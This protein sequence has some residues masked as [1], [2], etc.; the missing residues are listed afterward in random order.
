MTDTAREIQPDRSKKKDRIVAIV[1]ALSF[2]YLIN[3]TFG[4]FELL[5]DQLPGIGNIDEAFATY[6]CINSLLYFGVDIRWIF[7]RWWWK[8]HE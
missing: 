7:Q 1:G 4:L 5:P 8:K 6:V 2:L 3:P